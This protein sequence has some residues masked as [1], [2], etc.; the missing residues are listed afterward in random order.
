MV[1]VAP[2]LS[3]W[4]IVGSQ[5]HLV[6]SLLAFWVLDP[7]STRNTTLLPHPVLIHD[8]PVCRL[9]RYQLCLVHPR[10]VGSSRV[11]RCGGPSRTRRMSTTPRNVRGIS[12]TLQSNVPRV[13]GPVNDELGCAI[14]SAGGEME[15]GTCAAGVVCCMEITDPG[16][17]VYV[18]R[19][20]GG[21]ACTG[22]C[23]L[24][25]GRVQVDDAKSG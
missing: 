18:M 9:D 16:A 20:V 11:W 12:T 8:A 4:C 10:D 14:S 15:G 5:H 13:C 22:G 23:G 17:S 3:R 2:Y 1:W 19:G 6:T 25:D 24:V 7:Y 21:D